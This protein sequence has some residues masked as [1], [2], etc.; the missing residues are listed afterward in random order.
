MIRR[1][2]PKIS[3]PML[4][5]G[6]IA[7]I[8]S[9]VLAASSGWIIQTIVDLGFPVWVSLAV[10]IGSL[11]ML[12]LGYLNYDVLVLLTFSL[13]GFV[14]FEP[15]P[16]DLLMALVLG[17]GLVRGRLDLPALKYGWGVQFGLW[18]F[19]IVNFVS[20]FGVVNDPESWR[21]LGITVY[22]VALFLFTRMYT[23]QPEGLRMVITGYLIS[24]II[25]A[26]LVVLG[27]LGIGF[28]TST[29][30]WS[31]RGVGFFKDP[32]VFGPFIA[33]AALWAIDRFSQ[34]KRSTTQSVALIG[35]ALLLSFSAFYSLS[36][37]VWGSLTISSCIFAWFLARR[38]P[39]KGMRALFLMLTFA[40]VAIAFLQTFQI[41]GFFV[42]HL[43]LQGY[44]IV[45]FNTQYG[46]LL[47][48]LKHPFGVG[49]AGWPNT[50]S[51]YIK[52][53]AEHGI[54]GLAMLGI[55]IIV[56]ILPLIRQVSIKDSIYRIISPHMLLAIIIG[57]LVNSFVIDSIHWRHLWVLLGIAWAFQEIPDIK[58][59]RIN[60]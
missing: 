60:A 54:V 26:I 11:A 32:N 5:F 8:I 38:S 51:L 16:F 1:F 18:G 3:R 52:T 50:H 33:V 9:G 45:R 47:E 4:G 27:F 21:F 15:A 48:G 43:Q 53:F 30:G 59:E 23:S 25:N 34:P 49:P 35:L 6:L 22:M 28:F 40:I 24:A 10:P 12:V 13:I 2:Y 7:V 29:V 55:V 57:Q 17:M 36:R 19:I 14:R 56:S 41:K 44:D 37:A 58:L 39:L 46:G 20:M 31:V 42:E